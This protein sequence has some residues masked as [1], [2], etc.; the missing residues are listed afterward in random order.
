MQKDGDRRRLFQYL[1]RLNQ[2]DAAIELFLSSQSSAVKHGIRKVKLSGDI[3]S[4]TNQAAG[5]VFNGVSA[6]LQE[7]RCLFVTPVDGS[8]SLASPSADHLAVTSAITTWALDEVALFAQL[9]RRQIFFAEVSFDKV[10][11]C[12]RATFSA[13]KML[14]RQPVILRPS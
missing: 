13:C 6:A 3:L 10:Q 14:E 4:Y 12:L 1:V 5:V 9:L 2:K 11:D 8:G 7:Y